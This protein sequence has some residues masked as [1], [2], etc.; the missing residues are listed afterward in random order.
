MREDGYTKEELKIINESRKILDLPDLKITATAVRV[1]VFHS[2]AESVNVETKN[3]LTPQ[4]L[5]EAL[6][7]VEGIDIYP[8]VDDFPTQLTTTSDDSI[9]VGRIRKDV[10][11]ENGLDLWIVAD[12]LRKG[13]SSKCYSNS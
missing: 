8:S 1:P 5:N 6:D 9:H 2:H 4:K 3:P 11:V 12:N 7:A 10:S 13:C